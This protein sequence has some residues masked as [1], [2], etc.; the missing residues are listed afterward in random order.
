MACPIIGEHGNREYYDRLAF[1]FGVGVS[2]PSYSSRRIWKDQ[3]VR[4]GGNIQ[5]RI[6]AIGKCV[7]NMEE[8]KAEEYNQSPAGIAEA[9]NEITFDNTQYFANLKY[10]FFGLVANLGNYG[11]VGLSMTNFN[12]GRI[13]V[14]TALRPDGNGNYYEMSDVA[15]GL[16][17]AKKLTDRFSI[18]GVA[19]Y[20]HSSLFRMHTS[21]MAFDVGTLFKSPLLGLTIGMS[22]SNFGNAV[23][24]DGANTIIRHDVDLINSGNNDKILG[25]LRTNSW[26]LPLIFR[27]GVARSFN[28][29]ALGTIIMSADALHP[30]NN[31]ES[32]NFGMEYGFRQS[33]FLRVG[34]KSFGLEDSQEGLTFG[35][36]V[37]YHLLR[38]DYSYSDFGLLDN[39]QRFSFSVRF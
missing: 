36:G 16:A 30:N 1:Q 39:V 9:R 2:T 25:N 35:G 11:T 18:G 5:D 22:I 14:T 3:S 13:D 29:Q 7:N 33:V 38:V 21:A 34:Y 20:I 28:M 12:S 37:A 32:L 27:F 8:L 6:N 26:D 4:N 19:K 23:K 17:Y 24:Y 15:L 31:N 10:N